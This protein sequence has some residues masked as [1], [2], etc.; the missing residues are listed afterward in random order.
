MTLDENKFNRVF[1]AIVLVGMAVA[2][3]YTVIRGLNDPEDNPVSLLVAAFGSLMGILCVVCSANGSILTFLFG[4]FDV[5]IYAA[6]CFI[7]WRN[8]GPGLGNA[9]INGLYFVPMQFYGLFQWKKRGASQEEKV[10]ARRFNGRQWA[11]YSTLFIIGTAIAYLIL[12]ALDKEAASGFLQVAILMDAVSM[13]CNIL[14]QYL[15]SS[16]YMEQWVFWIIVNVASTLMWVLSFSKS[17]DTYSAIYAVKYFF[18]LLNA[19]NGL[20]I[21]IGLSKPADIL[22][23]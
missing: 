1:N 10:T 11:L 21:W 7:N 17:G 14:G 12:L 8:G 16:A 15:L 19:V 22:E 4:F 6:I 5:S 18:Y 2:I 13:V 9:L 23:N 3:V 20:R